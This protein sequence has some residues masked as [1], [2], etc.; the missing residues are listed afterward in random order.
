MLAIALLGVGVLYILDAQ[1]AQAAE[2]PTTQ[3]PLIVECSSC[4]SITPRL[5]SQMAFPADPC[6]ACHDE[7]PAEDRIIAPENVGRNLAQLEGRFATFGRW[8]NPIQKLDPRYRAAMDQFWQAKLLF[9]AADQSVDLLDVQT[10]IENAEVSLAQLENEA[11]WGF[12]ESLDGPEMPTEAITSSQPSP[13]PIEGHTLG[14]RLPVLRAPT[15]YGA[16]LELA[17]L[18][19]LS[20]CVLLVALRRAPP[21]EPH[22]II[23]NTNLPIRRRGSGNGRSPF[24]FALF[25]TNSLKLINCKGGSPGHNHFTNKF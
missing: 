8:D 1:N 12:W 21:S 11:K 16:S 6:D 22:N 18:L 23:L 3:N 14:D 13:V 5:T 19:V 4:H 7:A 25:F 9:G 24:L 20:L 10:L 15:E 17:G 2:L